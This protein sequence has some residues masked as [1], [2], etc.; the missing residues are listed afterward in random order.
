MLDTIHT[1]Y[2]KIADKFNISSIKPH[3]DTCWGFKVLLINGTT[4]AVETA[5]A[6]H[7]L[8]TYDERDKDVKKGIE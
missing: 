6:E 2:K 4:F 5:L 8:E 1:L 7:L 3:R